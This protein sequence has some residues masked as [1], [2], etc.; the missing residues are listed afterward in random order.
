MAKD[1]LGLRGE[2]TLILYDRN[3][4]IKKQETIKNLIVNTG[5]AEV[6]SLMGSGLGGTA[7]GYI[8]IGTGTTSPAAT[9]TALESETHRQA[10]TV[11]QTTVNVTNDTVQF[12]TTFSFTAS[13]AISEEGIFNDA[14]AGDMLS[15]VTFGAYNVEDGDQLKIIHKITVQ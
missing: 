11:T 12:E 6:A 2:V 15:R 8:A 14:T 3:G 10:A 13:Y 5:K 9:D 4:R 1:K 7:F